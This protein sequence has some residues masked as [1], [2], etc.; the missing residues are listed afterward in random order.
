MLLKGIVGQPVKD[1]AF[2]IFH[3]PQSDKKLHQ[4]FELSPLERSEKDRILLRLHRN[5]Q[6]IFDLLWSHSAIRARRNSGGETR[7]LK[8]NNEKIFIRRNRELGNPLLYC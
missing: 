6:K 3:T 7:D 4:Y 5:S 1:G 2:L 8:L